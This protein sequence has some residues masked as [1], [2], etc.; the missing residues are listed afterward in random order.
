MTASGHFSRIVSTSSSPNVWRTFGDVQ[1]SR[2]GTRRSR[3]HCMQGPIPLPVATRTRRRKRGATWINPMVG[4]PRTHISL[5]GFRIFFDVQS[6]ARD[7]TK[8][9]PG[10]PGSAT[11]PKLCHSV[12]GLPEIRTKLPA[13]GEATTIVSGLQAK[14]DPNT[15]RNQSIT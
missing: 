13:T 4:I 11:V 15:Y 14:L 2:I 8:E 7:T 12:R 3:M 10:F 6:P 9:K 1:R 5:G